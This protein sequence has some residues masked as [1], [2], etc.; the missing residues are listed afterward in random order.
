MAFVLLD[1]S[2]KVFVPTVNLSGGKGSVNGS[3]K[4]SAPLRSPKVSGINFI[5]ATVAC[6]PLVSPSKVMPSVTNPKYL[7]ITSSTKELISTFKIVEDEEYTDGNS[8]LLS[9][10]FKL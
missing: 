4:K 5:L 2:L 7:P 6:Y 3:L 10:G 1:V 8:T 9:Y